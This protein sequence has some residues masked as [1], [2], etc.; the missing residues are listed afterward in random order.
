MCKKASSSVY[1]SNLLNFKRLSRSI[2]LFLCQNVN[3]YESIDFQLFNNIRFFSS[4]NLFRYSRTEGNDSQHF[5]GRN[6]A[7]I[8]RDIICIYINWD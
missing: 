8:L 2:T 5:S 1:V 4:K 6:P 7:E 3:R